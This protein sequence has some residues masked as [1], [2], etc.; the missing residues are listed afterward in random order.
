[1]L[2]K[3]GTEQKHGSQKYGTE[4]DTILIFLDSLISD[5]SMSQKYDSTQIF[6]YRLMQIFLKPDNLPIFAWFFL[7]STHLS[8]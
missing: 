1:M 8:I 6:P 2:D 4:Q 7:F 5:Q 3:Y